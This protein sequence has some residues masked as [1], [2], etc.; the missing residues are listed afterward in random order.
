[1][2]FYVRFLK[3][4]EVFENFVSLTLVVTSLHHQNL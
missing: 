2:V 1:M 3:T 4:Y